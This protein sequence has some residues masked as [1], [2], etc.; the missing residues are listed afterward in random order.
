MVQMPGSMVS[1]AASSALEGEI[2]AQISSITFPVAPQFSPNSLES[3]GTMES[4]CHQ[5]SMQD[6]CI[7]GRAKC[8][9][10]E[11]SDAQKDADKPMQLN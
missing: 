6:E 1:F 3:R 4:M 10:M 8:N 11:H 9:E 5:C 2:R 7:L